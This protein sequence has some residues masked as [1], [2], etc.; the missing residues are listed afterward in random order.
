MTYW[1][2]DRNFDYFM[3]RSVLEYFVMGVNAN[4]EMT[5]FQTVKQ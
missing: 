5:K 4:Y 1:H 3:E 2:G